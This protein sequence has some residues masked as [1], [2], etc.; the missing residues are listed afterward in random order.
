M[1]NSIFNTYVVPTSGSVPL[2]TLSMR[3]PDAVSSIFSG[4]SY[5]F[6][7]APQQMTKTTL[8]LNAVMDVAGTAT[9]AGVQRIVDQFGQTLPVY[10]IKGTTGWKFHSLDGYVW[11]GLGSIQRVQAILTAFAVNNQNQIAGSQ[12]SSLYK[13]EF[14]DYFSGEYWEVVPVGPQGVTQSV[15]KPLYSYYEFNLAC[16]QKVSAQIPA[17]AVDAVASLLGANGLAALSLTTSAAG[18]FNSASNAVQSAYSSV[19]SFANTTL[20]NYV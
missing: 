20:T 13:L 15:D 16:V 19:T 3:G 12:G 14:Y 7:I 1:A 18:I 9:N 11:T 5:T 8:A 2:Y 4:Y 6:P 10:S 17:V